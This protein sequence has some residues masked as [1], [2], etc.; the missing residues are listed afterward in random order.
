MGIVIILLYIDYLKII[1]ILNMGFNVDYMY[2]F[3]FFLRE[4]CVYFKELM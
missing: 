3:K 1:I 4:I 2:F